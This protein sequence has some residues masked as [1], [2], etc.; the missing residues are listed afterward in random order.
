MRSIVAVYSCWGVSSA[1]V[2]GEITL[3]VVHPFAHRA[4]SWL[5]EG[6]RGRG[7]SRSAIG[8]GHEAGAHNP[9]GA[10]E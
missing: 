2:R 3:P 4:S 9:L 6:R 7:R 5:S 8:Q 1:M 10:P